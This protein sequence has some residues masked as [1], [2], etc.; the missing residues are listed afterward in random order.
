M[1]TAERRAKDKAKA[2]A[3]AKPSTSSTR[4]TGVK[5]V[6]SNAKKAAASPKPASTP[7]QRK[8][9]ENSELLREVKEMK[10]EGKKQLEIAEELGISAGRASFLIQ[11][12][13][14][15]P[16]DRYKGSTD[17]EL[18]AFVV[19]ARKNKKLSWALI[20]I[21]ANISENRARKLY[22]EAGYNDSGD[23]IGKGGRFP[24]GEAKPKKAAASAAAK[25]KSGGAT[26][27]A[28][29]KPAAA[30][31]EGGVQKTT[32]RRSAARAPKKAGAKK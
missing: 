27:R 1:P 26:A 6:A 17:K 24:T 4:K 32:A 29:R 31:T 28:P 30:K 23:R 15:S 3:A 19:D 7:T 16:K 20:M 14:V 8:R 13:M 12:A 5:S 21:R 2:E 18:K 11:A 10:N 9:A 25:G 22:R